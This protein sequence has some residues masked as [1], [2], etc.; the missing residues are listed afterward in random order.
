MQITLR[1]SDQNQHKARIETAIK[2]IEEDSCAEF[3]DIS[4]FMDGYMKEHQDKK[5]LPHY[6]QHKPAPAE[7]P[8]YLM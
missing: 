6:F 8:D 3:E 1:F 7:Y 4:D 2:M 5:Y